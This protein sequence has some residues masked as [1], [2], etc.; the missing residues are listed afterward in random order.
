MYD[1]NKLCNPIR[2]NVKFPIK[3]DQILIKFQEDFWEMLMKMIF[4]PKKGHRLLFHS[5]VIEEIEEMRNRLKNRNL[6]PDY[7]IY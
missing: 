6:R 1:S 7:R 2:M 5:C 4:C 3:I